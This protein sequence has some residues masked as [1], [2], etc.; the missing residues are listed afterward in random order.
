MHCCPGQHVTSKSVRST[1]LTRYGVLTNSTTY[2]DKLAKVLQRPIS[3]PPCGEKAAGYYPPPDGSWVEYI[4][5]TE[6]LR[7]GG[8]KSWPKAPKE[9]TWKDNWQ[10][11]DWTPTSPETTVTALHQQIGEMQQKADETARATEKR[12]DEDLKKELESEKKRS[13]RLESVLRKTGKEVRQIT[14]M[15]LDTVGKEKDKSPQYLVMV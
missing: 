4:P 1:N 14:N 5:R 10:N 11:Q 2:G 12:E 9:V 6:Q 8:K 15:L 3:E 7:E 13:R